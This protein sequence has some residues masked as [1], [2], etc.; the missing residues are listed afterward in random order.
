MKGNSTKTI[1][2]AV[3]ALCIMAIATIV[4]LS[5][6]KNKKAI[7]NEELL[8]SVLTEGE[9]IIIGQADATK[10]LI[11]YFDYNCKNCARFFKSTLPQ[12]EDEF[13]SRNQLNIV[14]KPINLSHNPAVSKAY[15]LLTCLNR[16]GSFHELHEILLIDPDFVHSLDFENFTNT[17]IQENEEIAQCMSTVED[18]FQT[19]NN[20]E[21]LHQLGFTAAPVFLL[22]NTAYKGS[23]DIAT[24]HNSFKR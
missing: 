18:D 16:I 14:L 23:I 12:I 8:T 10:S 1:T 6:Q 5:T 9:Q 15:Q 22:G 13:I 7:R 17:L 2:K 21:Q 24:I 19:N 20:K 11:V 3:I 4:I